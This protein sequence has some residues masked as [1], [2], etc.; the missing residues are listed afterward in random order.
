MATRVRVCVYARACV[1]EGV[2]MHVCVYILYTV[3]T[4]CIQYRAPIWV[5]SHFTKWRGVTKVRGMEQWFW[6]RW[7]GERFIYNNL[8][9]IIFQNF[10]KLVEF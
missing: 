3:Y 9:M 2:R 8:D 7:I 1:R 5:E 4:V 6:C 10:G